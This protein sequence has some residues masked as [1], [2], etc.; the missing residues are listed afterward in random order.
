MVS[1]AAMLNLNF[2]T[3]QNMNDLHYFWHTWENR[4][5]ADINV[6]ADRPAIPE[7]AAGEFWFGK[8]CEKLRYFNY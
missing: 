1:S 6:N 7:M 8:I 5:L 3:M 4:W 2:I